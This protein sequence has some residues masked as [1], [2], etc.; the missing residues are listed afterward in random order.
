MFKNEIKHQKEV[1]QDGSL[2]NEGPEGPTLLW[3]KVGQVEENRKVLQTAYGKHG[4][5]S[6]RQHQTLVGRVGLGAALPAWQGIR[7]CDSREPCWV[8]KQQRALTKLP[9]SWR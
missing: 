4:A 7:A 9:V 2:Q 3:L 6:W 1:S 8:L 5:C